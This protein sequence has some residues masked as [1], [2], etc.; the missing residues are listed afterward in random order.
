MT[1]KPLIHFVEVEDFYGFVSTTFNGLKIPKIFKES[2]DLS[3]KLTIRIKD[4]LH[5]VYAS[6]SRSFRNSDTAL[7]SSL[8]IKKISVPR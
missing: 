3:Y 1:R 7:Y 5:L 2:I 6:Q 8:R 4:L